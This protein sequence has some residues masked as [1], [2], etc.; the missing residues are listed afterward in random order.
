[1]LPSASKPPPSNRREVGSGTPVEVA[2]PKASTVVAFPSM[3]LDWP[4]WKAVASVWISRTFDDL[5]G[6]TKAKS[7]GTAKPN[8][9]VLAVFLST[10]P[11]STVP[12]VAN[13]ELG[14]VDAA[15][16]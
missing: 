9:I 15:V 14:N 16:L 1:M 6:G 11:G 2:G 4:S 13:G 5:P 7:G 12:S 3:T 8:P 10:S